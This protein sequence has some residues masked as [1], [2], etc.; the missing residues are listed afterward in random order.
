MV[1]PAFFTYVTTE[2][3][4]RHVRSAISKEQE[5]DL[6]SWLWSIFS[7]VSIHRG[8][9]NIYGCVDFCFFWKQ[10]WSVKRDSV[11]GDLLTS[12]WDREVKLKTGRLTVKPGDSI[13]QSHLL[14]RFCRVSVSYPVVVYFFVDMETR[15]TPLNYSSIMVVLSRHMTALFVWRVFCVVSRF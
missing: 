4:L 14:Y 5:T 6:T 13:R 1:T 7:S 12:P 11:R 8:S 2:L 9:N 3:R 15:I 10:Y